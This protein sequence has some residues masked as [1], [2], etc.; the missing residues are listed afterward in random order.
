MRI[1]IIEDEYKT[2]AYLRKGLSENRFIVDTATNGIDGLYFAS[3][4][5]YDLVI[6]DVMLPKIDG[7]T[8]IT[9]L[10]QM[11]PTMRILFLTA[12]G[13]IEDKIKGLELGADDYIVKPFI[14]SELLA[15]VRNLLRRGNTKII[16]TITIADLIIEISRFKV[17]RGSQRIALT[18]KEFQLLTYLGQHSGEV[19]SRTLIA[20]QVWDIHFDSD[21]NV[22][23]VAI[24]RIRTK[25]DDPFPNKLIHTVRGIGYVLEERH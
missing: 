25:I 13:A 1:L 12:R 5:Y 6:L 19:L 20:E 9:S 18:A 4:Y 22:V 14:F 24:R 21:S 3:Q 8:L 16:D 7:W 23:D 10:R 2:A 17:I 15:R 11:H